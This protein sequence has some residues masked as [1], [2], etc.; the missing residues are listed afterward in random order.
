MNTDFY[1]DKTP[2]EFFS[3]S[4]WNRD[5]TQ[6]SSNRQ[7]NTD[8]SLAR[9]LEYVQQLERRVEELESN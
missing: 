5:R 2:S 6:Y 3:D 9:L 8:E 7:L 4:G 1:Y